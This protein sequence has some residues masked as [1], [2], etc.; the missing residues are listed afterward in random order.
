[1]FKALS[2]SYLSRLYCSC[3]AYLILLGLLSWKLDFLSACLLLCII[4]M[5]FMMMRRKKKTTMEMLLHLFLFIYSDFLR[6]GYTYVSLTH[7]H[8]QYMTELTAGFHQLTAPL[9]FSADL[10][11]TTKKRSFRKTC[12]AT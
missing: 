2:C 10:N 11:K 9:K 3:T 7:I 1:M 4:C 5:H 8:M 12:S 6:N